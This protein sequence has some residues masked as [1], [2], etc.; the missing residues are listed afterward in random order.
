[1]SD[2]LHIN[3]RLQALVEVRITPTIEPEVR[4]ES[5]R[6]GEPAP[7]GS[8]AKRDRSAV[9]RRPIADLHTIQ[10]RSHAS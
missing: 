7:A 5:F 1:M 2:A 6:W 8:R 4:R 10:R 3:E 9:M